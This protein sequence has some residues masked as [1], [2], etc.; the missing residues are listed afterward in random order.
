[1]C[2]IAGY[3]G[4]NPPKQS[5]LQKTSDILSHR[6]P[7]GEG[8]YTHSIKKNSVAMVHRRLAILDLES[9]SNQPFI[10]KGTVLIY[11]GEIYNYIEIREELKRL[12]HIFKT[13][14]DTEVLIH[15]LYQWGHEALT[16][17]EGMWAFAWYNEQD[18]SLLLSRDRFGEKPLYIWPHKNGIYFA[19][20]VKGIA[21]LAEEWP[22]I[23]NSRLL[24]NLVNGYKSI[25]KTNQTYFKDISSLSPGT[26]L[27]IDTK[28]NSTPKKYWNPKFKE[29]ENLSYL[30]SV[31]MIKESLINAVKLRMRSDVPLAFCMSGG[32]DSNS[33]I[34]VASN[35]LEC[36]V[37]GFTIVNTDERYE[38]QDLIRQAVKQLGI[39]HTEIN[40]SKENFL[41]NL[42]KLV[43]SHDSPVSTIS[44]YVHWQLMEQV[45]KHNYKISI[46]GTAADELFSGYYDHHLF[47]LASVFKNK[48][49]FNESKRN[50]IKYVSP[51]V[52]NKFLK[53]PERFIN[54]PDFRDHIYLGRDTSGNLKKDFFEPFEEKEFKVSLLRKRMLNELFYESVPVILYE[55]DAN[56]MHNSIEN[57]SPFLDSKLFETSLKIPTQYL[58]KSG[59]AK[60]VLRDAMKNIVP[61]QI[62][63]SYRKVGF[64]APIEGLLDTKDKAI[65]ESI[66]DNSS[67]YEIVKR[68]N[69]EEILNQ[70]KI[71]N[72][73]SKFLFS[74]L[75]TK[76]FLENF[77][78]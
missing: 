57:R 32:V 27:K 26:F 10:Y 61:D 3:I 2:G 44:Y 66:L 35:V 36:N 8:F 28:F 52:R 47:Y 31:E 43:I 19:S 58:I 33:L 12:G 23:N 24:R 39:K 13:S 70:D 62:L 14:G 1:M 51:Y 69:I 78:R 4:Q 76:I 7:D 25:F 46:S 60:S 34:S 6:G 9:R 37:H 77:N 11:N 65:K 75:G 50:W 22:K 63:D 64:N 5:I 18:G 67:I 68:K 54:D 55:D 73:T 48:E 53:D 42:E 38:E 74:F 40:L 41:S 45:R 49:I 17:L 29:E 56:A 21:A 72:E 59:R 71:T 20:E 30:D 16:K 15:A